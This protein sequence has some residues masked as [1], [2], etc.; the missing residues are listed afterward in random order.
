MSVLSKIS[1][2]VSALILSAG[3]A[4]A[5]TINFNTVNNGFTAAPL[6]FSNGAD[7][8][9][10]TASRVSTSGALQGGRAH[11]ASFAGT[12][13]G[14]GICSEPFCNTVTGD[15]IK[16]ILDQHTID[17][18]NKG[19]LAILDFGSVFVKLLSVTFS[20]ADRNDQ[21]ALLDFATNSFTSGLLTGSSFI[22]TYV[23]ADGAS[24]SKF[25]FG[26]ID[27]K[28]EFKLQSISYDVIPPVSAVPLPAGGLL[29]ISGM[30]GLAALRRRRQAA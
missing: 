14:L 12:S 24:G 25:G 19:E 1:A 22:S 18:K 3:F 30:A 17:G 2:T 5:A 8:V 9:T 16:G 7:S 4:S 11:L 15:E 23:F 28:S 29:L 6:T 10:V 21:F 27:K 26:A 20:Y 13:G